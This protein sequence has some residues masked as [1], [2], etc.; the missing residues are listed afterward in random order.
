MT[1]QNHYLEEN[2][3]QVTD[4]LDELH[5]SAM[6]ILKGA[7]TGNFD[8]IEQSQVQIERSR[9]ILKALCKKKVFRDENNLLYMRKG[10]V[11]KASFF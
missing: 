7:T 4:N 8:L 5:K 10:W 1:I 3:E 11:R 6:N 9:K 2:Y